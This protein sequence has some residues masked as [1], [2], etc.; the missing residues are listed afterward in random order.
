MQPGCD[1]CVPLDCGSFDGEER[2]PQVWRVGF[3][4]LQP[5]GT[6]DTAGKIAGF[7]FLPE[8]ALAGRD[9]LGSI[10]TPP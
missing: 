7:L 2:K 10:S 8:A 1:Q 4:F 5:Q 9:F 3:G 6:P